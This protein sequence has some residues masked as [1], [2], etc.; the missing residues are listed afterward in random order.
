M[1]L[2]HK[3][4]LQLKHTNNHIPLRTNTPPSNSMMPIRKMAMATRIT[5]VM[6]SRVTMVAVVGEML[7]IRT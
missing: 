1:D 7:D 5:M 3:D 6:R 4:L 2:L